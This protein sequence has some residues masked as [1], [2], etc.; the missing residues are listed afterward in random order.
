MVLNGQSTAGVERAQQFG[1]GNAF[2]QVLELGLDGLQLDERVGH[3]EG[4]FFAVGVDVAEEVD[5]VGVGLDV[6]PVA[7][8]LG[9]E[10]GEELVVSR[11]DGA[12]V[13]DGDA[14]DGAEA[15]FEVIEDPE[16]GRGA[17]DERVDFV[18]VFA[19]VLEVLVE[20]A[21]LEGRWRGGEGSGQGVEEMVDSARGGFVFADA[22]EDMHGP[23]VGRDDTVHGC[24]DVGV[25]AREILRCFTGSEDEVVKLVV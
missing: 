6:A 8:E 5:G 4:G 20:D 14:V 18:L 22:F 24:A 25:V 17:G 23:L 2:A 9:P 11:G 3:V 10:R 15:V 7:A 1:R 16:E 13:V 12:V 19:H 21:L